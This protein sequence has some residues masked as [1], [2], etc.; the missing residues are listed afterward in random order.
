MTRVGRSRPGGGNGARERPRHDCQRQNDGNDEFGALGFGD[1][2]AAGD[3]ADQ[4]GEER[5]AFHQC[6][7][8]GQFGGL[9]LLRQDAVLHRPEQRRDH[10]EQRERHEQDRHRV[11]V[12]ADGCKRGDGNLGKLDARGD[13]G[14][15]EA[16]GDLPAQRRQD[17]ERRDEDDAGQRHQH[18][19]MSAGDPARTA[20][21]E[22]D[23]HDQ[24]VLEEIVVEGRAELAPEQRRKAPRRHEV[25]EHRLPLALIRALR[26]SPRQERLVQRASVNIVAS[27]RLQQNDGRLMND[28]HIKFDHW[29]QASRCRRNDNV[30]YSIEQTSRHGTSTLHR[31]RNLHT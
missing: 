16:V 10:A 11:Q 21:P 26:P 29:M 28:V 7:A 2:N 23:Q 4:D 30:R 17:E 8:C 24:R 20:E 1:G 12:E 19:A 15:V 3:G 9:E 22:Q 14:L 31:R 18:R 5:G 25:L 6:V 13:V 27:C